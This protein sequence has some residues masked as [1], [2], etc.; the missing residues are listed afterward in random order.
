[1]TDHKTLSEGEIVRRLQTILREHPIH[2]GLSIEWRDETVRRAIELIE[3]AAAP[4]PLDGETRVP[5]WV[6]QSLREIDPAGLKAGSPAAFH[7]H[8]RHALDI[9]ID[10]LS[11]STQTEASLMSDR[12]A[13]LAR[14][15]EA[16]GVRND[17]MSSPKELFARCIL[18]IPLLARTC[19]ATEE[20]A[21][22]PVREYRRAH[23][24][25]SLGVIDLRRIWAEA[26]LYIV[27]KKG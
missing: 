14:L 15:M 9:A 25:G 7:R 27:K 3:I 5:D 24:D 2:A 16:L 12:Q 19:E 6:I 20:E 18:A 13:D 1:M 17:G 10:F 21:E 11:G 23:P 4:K 26:G 8:Y 22:T